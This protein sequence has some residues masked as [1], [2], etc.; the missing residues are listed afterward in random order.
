MYFIFKFKQCFVYKLIYAT[1]FL[2]LILRLLFLTSKCN[3]VD[4][5]GGMEE[6]T[7]PPTTQLYTSYFSRA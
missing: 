1:V 3:A 7:H 5:G 4:S 6:I 2:G